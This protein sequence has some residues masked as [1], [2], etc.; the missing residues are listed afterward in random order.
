MSPYTLARKKWILGF[1]DATVIA[2]FIRKP[3]A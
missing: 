3:L 2:L 1:P